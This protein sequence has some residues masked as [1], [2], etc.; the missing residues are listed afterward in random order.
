MT[1]KPITLTDDEIWRFWWSRPE[2]PDGEDDSMEAEFVAAV[3]RAIAAE[4]AASPTAAILAVD[5]V[6]NEHAENILN[7]WLDNQHPDDVA[8]GAFASKMRQK[9]AAARAKGRGGWNDKAQCSDETLSRMLRE[10]VE[11]GD[12]VDVANFA[13]MLSQRGERIT[14]PPRA[15]SETTAS[16]SVQGVMGAEVVGTRKIHGLTINRDSD[17]SF[18]VDGLDRW[19]CASPENDAESNLESEMCL[20]LERLWT[21]AA[22]QGAGTGE[23]R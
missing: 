2:V 4:L 20:L 1:D 7:S 19:F 23:K 5:A 16:A 21:A 3:K 14:T 9:M 13:M 6:A 11:K 12:P 22:P 10:H 17:G 15:G 18:S 8:V